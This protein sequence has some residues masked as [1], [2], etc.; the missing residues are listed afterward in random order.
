[1]FRSKPEN[2]RWNI[3]QNAVQT[4][5]RELDTEAQAK[6]ELAVK[7][8]ILQ[9]EQQQTEPAIQVLEE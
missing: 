1:M 3:A 9:Q 5:L 8:A 4:Y 2:F 6:N 7:M